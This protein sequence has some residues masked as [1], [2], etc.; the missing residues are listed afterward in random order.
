[1]H[2][3]Y[4]G[5]V[6]NNGRVGAIAQRDVQNSALL[7]EVDLL[8]GEHRVARLFHATRAKLYAEDRAQG[9]GELLN[10]ILKK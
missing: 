3:A 10:Y 5:A 6:H 1:M 7:R 2:F 9:M 8:A 4:V